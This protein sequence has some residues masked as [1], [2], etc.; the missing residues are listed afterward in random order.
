L[1]N[2]KLNTEKNMVLLN[3]AKDSAKQSMLGKSSTK[4]ANHPETSLKN[5]PQAKRLGKKRNVQK[6]EMS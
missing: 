5:V 2:I 3:T 6:G 4:R 1:I